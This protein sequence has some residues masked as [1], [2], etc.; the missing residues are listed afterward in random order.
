MGD[1]DYKTNGVDT[2][3]EARSKGVKFFLTYLGLYLAVWGIVFIVSR[4][5]NP[6][7]FQDSLEVSYM[8]WGFGLSIALAA[9]LGVIPA[10]ILANAKKKGYVYFCVLGFLLINILSFILI[11]TALKPLCWIPVLYSVHFLLMLDALSIGDTMLMGISPV[12]DFFGL[13]IFPTAYYFL[14]VWV[15]LRVAERRWRKAL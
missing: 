14:L 10:V 8:F 2:N 6:D 4:V 12:L 15:S 5:C 7:Y 13:V 1:E 3:N 11:G 9:V